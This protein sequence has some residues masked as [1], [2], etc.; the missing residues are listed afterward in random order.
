MNS[1]L[2]AA[3]AHRV[4]IYYQ[5]QYDNSLAANSPFGHYV[6]VLPLI[7]VITHLLLAAFH[8]NFDDV[9][10]HL[11]DFVPE[12]P[13]FD[14]MWGEIAILQS[15]GIK[16]IGML[17]GA[18]PGTYNPCLTPE[19]FDTYYP[20]LAGYITR[21]HIDGLDLDVEQDMPLD[22][23]IH[24]IKT[25]K[26]DFGD[27][28][29]ITLAPVASALVEGANLSGFDYIELE[30]KVGH[31]IS[32]YNAQFYSGFG[33]FFPDDL[34]LDIVGFG[35]GLDPSRLV[36]TTLTSPDEGSGFIDIDSVTS[37][38]QALAQKQ[39]FN[40]GGV[41]GW[42]YFNSLPGGNNQPYL[43]ANLMASTMAELQ[44]NQTQLAKSKSTRSRVL[45]RS[46]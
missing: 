5:S 11:N 10:V 33:T 35:Q 17:G 31:H 36:A 19:N 46:K 44:T 41:A 38:V 14:Q 42:E 4:A 27:D 23:A 29:I 12:A 39:H 43:W 13:F 18:A 15:T 21:Y 37:S 24:L 20:V 16:V 34:Y 8:L 6:T 28:F 26:A 3:D 25:L 2:V 1:S 30:N 9:S 22:D 32:W 7:G 45:P 40:F